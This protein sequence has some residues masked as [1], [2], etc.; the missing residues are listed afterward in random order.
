MTVATNATARGWRADL[1]VPWGIFADE[2][3]PAGGHP[4]P[5]WR[6]NVYRYDY[7]D[8]PD[9]PF[10]LTAWSPTHDASFHVPARF[11]RATLVE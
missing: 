10:E 1:F 5:H 8:G 7:P 11:G 3:R 9:A 4:W 2:F 6:L